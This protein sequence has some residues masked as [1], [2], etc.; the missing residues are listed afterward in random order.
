MVMNAMC[1][2]CRKLHDPTEPER[3]YKEK[4]LKKEFHCSNPQNQKPMFDFKAKWM[5]HKLKEALA[6]P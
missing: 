4:D 5:G 1:E 2:L 3:V 6:S